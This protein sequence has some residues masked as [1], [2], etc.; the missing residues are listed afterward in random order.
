MRDVAKSVIG[1][2]WAVSLYSLQQ[3]ARLARTG[4]AA[5][6]AA[7]LDEVTRALQGHLAAATAM[8]FRVGDDWQ[9][10]AVD[11][12]WDAATWQVGDLRKAVSSLDPRDILSGKRPAASASSATTFASDAQ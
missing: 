11:V 5:A 9:R 2:S 8:P 1:F 4:T 12:V 10:R 3:A 7:D 6:A